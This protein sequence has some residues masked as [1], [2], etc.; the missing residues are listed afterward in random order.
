MDSNIIQ[1]SQ[2]FSKSKIETLRGTLTSVVP[3]GAFVA[4]FGSYARLEASEQSDLDYLIL[5]SDDR[6]NTPKFSD[7]VFSIISKIVPTPPASDGV[8][9]QTRK[10][11]EML[12]NFGGENDANDA[13]TRRL[14]LLLEGEWLTGQQAF[15]DLRRKIIEKYTDGVRDDHQLT[16]FLLNDIIRYWR[17]VTVDYMYKT[18]ESTK[19]WAPRNIK[20]IFS[21][22]LMYAGGLFSVGATIDRT[23]KEK[24]EFLCEMFDKPVIDRLAFICGHQ[25]CTNILRSYSIF[26]ESMANPE[27]RKALSKLKHGNHENEEFRKLKNEGHRFTRE[28]LNLFERTFDSTHPIRRAVVF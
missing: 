10:I 22:K 11:D 5:Y 23:P 15:K 6:L 3:A 4:T 19:P 21:R 1:R 26:L 24:I 17:T 25:E 18:T 12:Q 9:A 13:I 2:V 14:L 7:T 28:L 8:F 27:T 16:L 20:L